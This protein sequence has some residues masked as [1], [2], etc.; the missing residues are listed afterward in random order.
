[1][2]GAGTGAGTARRF[3]AWGAWRRTLSLPPLRPWAAAVPAPSYSPVPWSV[4]RGAGAG[5]PRRSAAPGPAARGRGAAHAKLLSCSARSEVAA[6]T[7]ASR[8]LPGL[9]GSEHTPTRHHP[10]PAPAPAAPA[11][12]RQHPARRPRGAQVSSGGGLGAGAPYLPARPG[13]GGLRGE[14]P[15]NPVARGRGT[16]ALCKC[17]W[18]GFFRPPAAPAPSRSKAGCADG[19]GAA[20]PSP[21]AGGFAGGGE[22]LRLGLRSPT[23]AR[24]PM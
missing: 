9:G 11:Q 12:S 19:N 18:L 5:A 21:P 16:F 22:G 23:G 3:Q 13:E 6:E 17:E 4:P 20:F 7:A 1:M 14:D 2:R 24:E 10:L 15:F 8:P